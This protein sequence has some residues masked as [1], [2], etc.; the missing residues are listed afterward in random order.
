[1]GLAAYK[2]TNDAHLKNTQ[3]NTIFWLRNCLF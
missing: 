1:M 3:K 2:K